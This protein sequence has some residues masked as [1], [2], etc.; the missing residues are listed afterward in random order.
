MGGMEWLRNQY[1]HK[2]ENTINDGERNDDEKEKMRTR[3]V[4]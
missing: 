4:E 2:I 3:R 1:I